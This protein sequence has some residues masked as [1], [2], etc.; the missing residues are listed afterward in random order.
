MS[1]LEWDLDN[2]IMLG[3]LFLR[4]VE[5]NMNNYEDSTVRFGITGKGIQPNYEI[6]YPKGTIHIFS[7]ASHKIYHS[8]DKFNKSRISEPFTFSQIQEA[9]SKSTYKPL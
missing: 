8:V 3:K 1:Y 6:T 2:I 4:N 5:S 7:G 9:L